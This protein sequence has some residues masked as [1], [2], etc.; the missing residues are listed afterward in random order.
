M[1]NKRKI[2]YSLVSLCLI[3]S[4]LSSAPALAKGA[5]KLG[6]VDNNGYVTAV[7]ARTVL[8]VSAKLVNNLSSAAMV[9]ADFNKDGRITAVDA[10]KILRVS[11]KLDKHPD[12][13]AHMND[14]EL[15]KT[16]Q[17]ILDAYTI[18]MNKA[19]ASAPAYKSKEFQALPSDKNNRKITRSPFT[20]NMVLNLAE[21]AFLL[22]AD[23]PIQ[24]RQKGNS[25]EWFPI[26]K[27]S[28]GNYLTDV[29]FIKSAS[30]KRMANG[31]I[32]LS[33]TLKEEFNS[34]PTPE[35]S[36][37]PLS[38][39]GSMFYPLPMS[40]ITAALEDPTVASLVTINIFDIKYHNCTA[41]IEYNPA[42]NELVSM[43]Q[44]MVAGL[45]VKGNAKL[46]QFEFFQNIYSTL[47]TWDFVY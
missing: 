38:K 4:L 27:N 32:S 15:P 6:D 43:E 41:S 23:A 9:A 28:K 33:I 39:I 8:R 7:D 13:I 44:Q 17:E 21:S 36:D 16:N 14:T 37:A 10:R 2:I 1:K 12:D 29:N 42:N 24:D 25:M 45:D 31:N 20:V 11:A 35:N 46:L 47:K 19:K 26:V 18:V 40:E 30:S 22:E 3:F 5:Y 34:Q